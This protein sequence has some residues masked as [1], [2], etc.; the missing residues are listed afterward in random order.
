[1]RGRVFCVFFPFILDIKFVGCTSRGHTGGRSHKIS[2]PPSFCGIDTPKDSWFTGNHCRC[3]GKRRRMGYGLEWSK[4]GIFRTKV[5]WVY[6]PNCRT[7]EPASA[8]IS[9]VAKDKNG[10]D[11]KN[12]NKDKDEDDASIKPQVPLKKLFSYADRQD[13]IFMAIGTFAA[14]VHSV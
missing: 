10:P 9:T 12:G 13:V 1:K 2:H 7:K 8:A 11:A 5:E 3:G 4:V 6:P 14:C